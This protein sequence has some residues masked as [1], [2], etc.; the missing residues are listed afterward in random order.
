MYLVE[1]FGVVVIICWGY[2][3]VHAGKTL[4]IIQNSTAEKTFVGM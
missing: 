4:L 2:L 3:A 1:A